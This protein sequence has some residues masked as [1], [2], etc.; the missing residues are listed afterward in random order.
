MANCPPTVRAALE[1]EGI[2][3]FSEYRKD[4]SSQTEKWQKGR[5]RKLEFELKPEQ[6][7]K[8]AWVVSKSEPFKVLKSADIR[9]EGTHVTMFFESTAQAPQGTYDLVKWMS[10]NSVE[11]VEDAVSCK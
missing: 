9:H 3:Q 4:T 5:D 6:K 1:P 11:H 2:T 8:A 10:D 7:V